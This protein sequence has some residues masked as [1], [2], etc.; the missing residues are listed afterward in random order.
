MN[1]VENVVENLG[2]GEEDPASPQHPPCGGFRDGAGLSM[3]VIQGNSLIL[4]LNVCHVQSRPDCH[5]SEVIHIYIII[6]RRMPSPT[7]KEYES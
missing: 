2:E 6:T 1:F 4:I 5:S 3:D 7:S